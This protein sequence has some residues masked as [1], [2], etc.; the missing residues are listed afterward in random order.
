MTENII[1]RVG[2]PEPFNRDRLSQQIRGTG[3]V[4]EVGVKILHIDSSQ[5]SSD[6]RSDASALVAGLV[7]DRSDATRALW[8]VD[9]VHGHFTPR[10]LPGRIVD[11]LV[12]HQGYQRASIEKI[13]G[14]G[15]LSAL[16]SN[17]CEK[18]G[19]AFPKL[20]WLPM[21]VQASKARRIGRLARLSNENRLFLVAGNWNDA[22]LDQASK[23]DPTSKNNHGRGDDLLDAS[24]GLVNGVF[25]L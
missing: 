1:T 23:F 2:V 3:S 15:F 22:W 16:I 5:C 9:V 8:I 6:S 10:E 18:R 13:I 21:Q 24:C 17:E 7:V 11:F 12:K 14:S 20:L 4:P 19:I 25:G